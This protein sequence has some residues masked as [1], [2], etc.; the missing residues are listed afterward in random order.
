MTEQLLYRAEED[1]TKEAVVSMS[2]RKMN[3]NLL[4]GRHI[5]LLA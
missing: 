4:A 2:P 5:N 3:A 1:G